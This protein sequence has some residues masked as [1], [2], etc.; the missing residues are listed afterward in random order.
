MIVAAYQMKTKTVG[1]TVSAQGLGCMGMS[2]F[3]G[4]SDEDEAAP[5]RSRG[6]AGGPGRRRPGPGDS[7]GASARLAPPRE[8]NLDTA[9]LGLAGRCMA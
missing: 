9:V 3:Y 2:E 5:G 7:G 4:T 6:E 1:L 8:R